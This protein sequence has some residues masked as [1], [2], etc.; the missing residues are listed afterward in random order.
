MLCVRSNGQFARVVIAPGGPSF[1]APFTLD[2][3]FRFGELHELIEVVAYMIQVRMSKLMLETIED[4]E[5][6]NNMA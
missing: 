6:E 2:S 1:A 3:G 4:V 5:K